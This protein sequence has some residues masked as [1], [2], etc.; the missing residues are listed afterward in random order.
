LTRADPRCQWS[1][2]EGL[3]PLYWGGGPLII[4]FF[5]SHEEYDGVDAETV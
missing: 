3:L 1:V 2:R 4:R 5:G